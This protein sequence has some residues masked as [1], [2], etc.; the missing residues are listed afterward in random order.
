L[1]TVFLDFKVGGDICNSEFLWSVS[2]GYDFGKVNIAYQYF[3]HDFM[4][5]TTTAISIGFYL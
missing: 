2:V 4:Y 3:D 1:E 5:E